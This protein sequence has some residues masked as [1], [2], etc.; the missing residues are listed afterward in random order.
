MLETI[1]GLPFALLGAG[2]AAALSGIGSA[3]G[4]GMA[5]EAGTGLLSEDPSKFGKVM[6]LQVIPGTQGLYGLVVWFFAIFSM[7][8]MDGSAMN[9]DL[10]TGMQYF[11]ACLPMALGGL[12]SAIAQGRVAAGSINILAKK[13][14]DWSKGMVLCITVEFYAILALL[15][16]ML[17]IIYIS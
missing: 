15:A 10:A 17:M 8:L 12:F 6:I 4:T 13:P 2:L 7:G 11:V 5:G 9:M 14:D 16:S 3:K 1:G